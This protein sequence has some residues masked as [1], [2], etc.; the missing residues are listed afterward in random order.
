MDS[1]QLK[2]MIY[3]NLG[4]LKHS[5]A[6]NHFATDSDL[7]LERLAEAQQNYRE[8]MRLSNQNVSIGKNQELVLNERRLVKELKEMQKN[9]SC[10]IGLV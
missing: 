1:D 9:L 8:A 10:E 4:V 6:R 7:A 3:Q 5:D 2:G